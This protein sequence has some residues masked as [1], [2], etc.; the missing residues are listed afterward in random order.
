MRDYT[1]WYVEK[2]TNVLLKTAFLAGE[3]QFSQTFHATEIGVEN[4]CRY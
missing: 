4:K 2:L 1:K 3:W